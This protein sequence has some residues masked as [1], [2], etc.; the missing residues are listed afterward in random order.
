MA[1]ANHPLVMNF[2]LPTILVASA[3]A[4]SSFGEADIKDAEKAVPP[5]AESSGEWKPDLAWVDPV[6]T[7]PVSKEFQRIRDK[8]GCDEAKWP[9]IPT[10]CFPD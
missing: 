6:I 3:L 5:Q 8:A 9:D 10:V 4:L 7:G 1:I 2:V